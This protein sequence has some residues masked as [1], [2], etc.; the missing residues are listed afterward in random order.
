MKTQKY[1][2]LALLTLIIIISSSCELTRELDDFE[3]L[4]ALDADEAITNEA[5]AELAL[6]GIYSGFRQRSTAPGN[7]QIYLIPSVMSGLLEVSAVSQGPEEQGYATNNPIPAGATINLGAYTRMYD[8]VNRANW[9]LEKI[10]P[11]TD[12]NFDNPERKAEIIAEAKALRATANF[13]LLRLWGQFY[14][15]NSTF[16]ITLRTDPARSATAFPRN[17]VAEVYQ[18]II[19]DLDDAIDAAPA[20]RAKFYTSAT[21]AKGLKA[22]VL[23]YSGN[24]DEA[25][26]LAGEIIDSADSNFVLAPSYE[27]I[28]LDHSSEELFNSTEILFGSKGEPQ[29]SLGIGTFTGPSFAGVN[30]DFVEFALQ[31][32]SVSGQNI[33]Y[34]STRVSS[35]VFDLGGTFGLDT[36]KY[37]TRSSADLFEMI[38]HLRMAEVYLIFA[39][40]QARSAGTVTPEALNA[41]NAVRLRAGAIAS[42]EDGFTTYPATITL[43]EFLEAVRIEKY[44]ELAVETGEEWFDLVRYHFVDGFDVTTVKPTATDP[45]K[46]ILPID[47]ATIEAGGQCYNTKPGVLK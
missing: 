1:I 44:I 21:Y 17:T 25:A 3:P 35:T 24:Y 22:K 8:I 42:N 29:A 12:D 5:T 13:Y 36:F 20:L 2:K 31:S 46:Y 43:P 14:D 23:L 16:G 10:A 40:A 39:E 47:A 34:D 15:I 9:L 28:F 37:N 33:T 30:P 38:Y 7:P 32:T 18:A 6:T 26:A 11:I 41:L 27:G 4:F 19:G 45:N